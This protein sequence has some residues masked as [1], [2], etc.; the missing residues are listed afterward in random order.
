MGA[1]MWV[2]VLSRHGDVAARERIEGPEARVGR[3]FDNDVVIDD[4]GAYTKPWTVQW[5]INWTANGELKEYIC[6]ENNQY[7]LRLT[8][9]FGQPVFGRKP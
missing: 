9:D 4:P 7:L 5:N 6:Q 2:E 3:A 8:D 1:V